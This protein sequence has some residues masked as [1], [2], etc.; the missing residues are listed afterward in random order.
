[1]KKKAIIIL[2]IAFL[3]LLSTQ[4]RAQ[5]IDVVGF[6]TTAD[7]CGA[8][9]ATTD[10]KELSVENTANEH[11]SCAANKS[12]STGKYY[13]EALI[14]SDGSNRQYIGVG[15]DGI[16]IGSTSVAADDG[17]WGM[18]IDSTG[19]NDG[20]KVHNGAEAGSSY[21][22]NVNDAGD[23]IMVAVDFDNSE[24]WF[25][26]EGTWCNSGN[27]ATRANPAYTNVAG[28]LFPA[29]GTSGS[30]TK[31]LTYNFTDFAYAIPSGFSSW[32]E[33]AGPSGDETQ[34]FTVTAVDTYDGT[35]ISNFSVMVSN[36]SNFYNFTT[37][38]GT[39]HIDNRTIGNFSS[40]YTF[41]F[42][43]NQSGGYINHSLGPITL[44][45]AGSF[46]GDLYQ[47]VLQVEAF[48]VITNNHIGQF[49]ASLPLQSNQSNGDS[50]DP[51]TPLCSGN[52]D[53]KATLLV[54]AGTYNVTGN[55]TLSDYLNATRTVTINALQ[56]ITVNV[57]M[58]KVKV[59]LNASNIVSKEPVQNFTVE[60]A[61]TSYT[62]TAS[63]N[64]Y[65]V[66]FLLLNQTYNFTF[67]SSDFAT[68]TDVIDVNITHSL[69]N[70]TFQVY[71]TNSI[72]INIY[73]EIL[74]KPA[75]FFNATPVDIEI[76]GTPFSTNFTTLNG[77][78]YVDLLGAQD[79]QIRYVSNDY[80]I[81]DYFFTLINQTY[82]AIDLFL[83]SEGN[84]T[85]VTFTVRNS[86]GVPVENATVSLERYYVVQ[87]QYFVVAM[88]RTNSEGKVILDV[89]FNDALYRI[90]LEGLGITY[91]GLPGKIIATA[92]DLTLPTTSTTLSG[93]DFS[94]LI[95]TIYPRSQTL[96]N[97]TTYTFSFNMTS[98][99]LDIQDC[100]FKIKNGTKTLSESSSTFSTDSCN[101]S[102]SYNVGNF[103]EL[104]A[105]AHWQLSGGINN[106]F[107]KSYIVLHYVPGNFTMKNFI[108]DINKLSGAGFSDST[109]FLIGFIVVFAVVLGAAG[110]SQTFRDTETL[111]ITALG[112]ILL[113]SYFG[114]LTIN[115]AGIPEIVG[116]EPGYLKQYIIFYLA[117]LATLGYIINKRI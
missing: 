51:L 33:V 62:A 84:S 48:E 10:P 40:D 36:S 60:V 111:M 23:V 105:S 17:F 109:R 88:G 92:V 107:A 37:G 95:Y 112:T 54:K 68:V 9:W 64:D 21:C 66:E 25:G 41:L 15:D 7:S 100:F 27:P 4:V 65:N 113:V 11:S 52:C 59:N 79:Y 76:I 30:G 80:S 20:N 31:H 45:D 74:G 35:S 29:I 114:W 39:I 91:T 103:T 22:G 26:N 70:H 104:T 98:S 78:I 32:Q 72:D 99:A 82:N 83:L 93:S 6:N 77:S 115:Y 61:T 97:G 14:V 42:S 86:E 46:Q 75:N 38:N 90:K 96:I 58:G 50:Q 18:L 16:P 73:D 57:T 12:Y 106:T 101:I 34:T 89:D 24:I 108:D 116:T 55:R 19:S 56:N 5:A 1:M 8:N 53:G 28:I 94:G 47:A 44:N 71:T 2:A 87:D 117:L 81:R 67:S 49:F 13:F 110:T 102:I 85:D 63:T 3:L 43:S 69:L